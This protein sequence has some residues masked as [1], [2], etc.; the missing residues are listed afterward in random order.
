MTDEFKDELTE[1]EITPQTTDETGNGEAP[2]FR[3]EDVM[4]YAMQLLSFLPAEMA[5]MFCINLFGE[6]AWTHLGIRAD[7]AS[8]ETKTDFP[9]ARLSID[10]INALLPLTEGRFDPH[11]VR[12]LRNLVS[13]LQMNFVQRYTPEQQ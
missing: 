4:G 7:R 6:M 1:D 5:L 3:P 8:G 11:A 12:D 13:S 9:Q 2:Q 10:A